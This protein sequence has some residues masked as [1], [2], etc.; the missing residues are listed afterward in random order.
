LEANEKKRWWDFKHYAKLANIIKKGQYDLVQA[1]A[2]D[3][4]KYASLSKKIF[5]WKAKLVFRNANKIK[6]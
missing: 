4:L 2:G 6:K 5:G 3:T 1:N